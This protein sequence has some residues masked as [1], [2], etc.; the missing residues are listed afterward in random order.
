MKSL[1]A[2]V[3]TGVCLLVCVATVSAQSLGDLA[4]REE[5]RRKTLTTASKVYTNQSLRSEGAPAG[6][7]AGSSPAPPPAE[8]A[9]ATPADGEPGSDPDTDV[10][11]GGPGD[12]PAGSALTEADWRKRIVDARQAKSRA[13]ILADA[14]QSRINVLAA[15]FVN[16][17]DPA[18]RDVVADDRQKALATLARVTDEIEQHRQ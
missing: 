3:A 9:A 1:L 13:R 10:E 12:G 16:R 6:P 5:E 7:V 18:Q 15:D 8:S 4:R 17:D 14:L 11:G 2:H